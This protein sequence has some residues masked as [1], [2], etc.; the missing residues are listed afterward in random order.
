MNAANYPIASSVKFTHNI[1]DKQILVLQQN[2]VLNLSTGIEYQ[3][4]LNYINTML[5]SL[6]NSKFKLKIP[7]PVII[8]KHDEDDFVACFYEAGCYGYGVSIPESL[9]S[10][11]DNIVSMYEDLINETEDTLTEEPLKWRN[12]LM[13]FI[14]GV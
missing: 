12:T 11:Q 14:T 3:K 4:E 1:F 2:H 5:S 7:A 10:L 9:S 6:G 13:E 8:E